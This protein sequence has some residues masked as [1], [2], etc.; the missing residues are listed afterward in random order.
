MPRQPRQIDPND[1][2]YIRI[3]IGILK[4]ASIRKREVKITQPYKV[5]LDDD[6]KEFELVIQLAVVQRLPR[7]AS[8]RNEQSDPGDQEQA[9]ER[10]YFNPSR[11]HGPKGRAKSFYYDVVWLNLHNTEVHNLL[12]ISR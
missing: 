3:V 10:Q 2:T 12:N 1:T 9:L 5:D 6:G 11:M 8:W 4:N 7:T